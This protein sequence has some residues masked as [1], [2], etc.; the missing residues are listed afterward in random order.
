MG[1]PRAVNKETALER[2][3]P[4]LELGTARRLTLRCSESCGESK[5][6]GH[7]RGETDASIFSLALAKTKGNLA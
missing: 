7:T 2:R 1:K 4:L 5:D 3:R 6:R